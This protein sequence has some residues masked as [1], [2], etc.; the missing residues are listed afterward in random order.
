[1]AKL[2]VRSNPLIKFLRIAHADTIARPPA[3]TTTP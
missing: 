2:H 1:L 3:G